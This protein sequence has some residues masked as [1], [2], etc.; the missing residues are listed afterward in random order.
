MVVVV[1]KSCR[2]GWMG[3][4]ERKVVEDRKTRMMEEGS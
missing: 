1:V 4:Q 2:W 3:A